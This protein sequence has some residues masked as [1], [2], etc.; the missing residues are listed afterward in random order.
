MQIARTALLCL[1]SCIW[2]LSGNLARYDREG[3]L[4]GVLSHFADVKHHL[5]GSAEP[6]FQKP[7]FTVVGRRD[8]SGGFRQMGKFA[9][10]IFSNTFLLLTIKNSLLSA[11]S[12]V[13][14]H[15]KI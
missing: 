2:V 6:K 11:K 5:F 15:E 7:F 9:F 14:L 12:F 3:K 4:H 8:M 1:G 10:F 13:G